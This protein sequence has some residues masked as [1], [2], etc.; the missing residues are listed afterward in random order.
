MRRKKH[1]YKIFSLFFHPS[2]GSVGIPV[3]LSLFPQ[4]LFHSKDFSSHG[5][6]AAC[7]CHRCAPSIHPK[8]P[9]WL[10]Y[11]TISHPYQESSKSK[12]MSFCMEKKQT[13]A[14]LWVCRRLQRTCL[15]STWI[16]LCS[17]CFLLLEPLHDT[18][19]AQKPGASADWYRS[20]KSRLARTGSPIRSIST[21]NGPVTF[22]KVHSEPFKLY[23]FPLSCILS[24]FK[25]QRL[26]ATLKILEIS[27]IL[28]LVS[29]IYLFIY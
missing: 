11:R 26:T 29:F 20:H 18:N 3:S 4:F 8:H 7:G 27:T 1:T 5:W 15:Q 12:Q 21:S 19:P 6:N 25:Q 24:A 9:H 16:H 10:T 17:V 13:R 2:L 14:L 23:T 22:K 28:Y